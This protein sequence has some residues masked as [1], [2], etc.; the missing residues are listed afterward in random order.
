[1]EVGSYGVDVSMTLVGFVSLSQDNCHRCQRHIPQPPSLAGHRRTKAYEGWQ[2]AL[3]SEDLVLEIQQKPSLYISWARRPFPLE[4]ELGKG[5]AG[6]RKWAQTI[7]ISHEMQ[8]TF[9]R[10]GHL[11]L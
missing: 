2:K 10:S 4:R 8:P 11:P 3:S 6:K 9:L 5:L 7:V 1:M